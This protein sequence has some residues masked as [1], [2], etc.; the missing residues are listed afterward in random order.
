MGWRGK[1]VGDLKLGVLHI[2]HHARREEQSPPLTRVVFFFFRCLCLQ[3]PCSFPA[4]YSAGYI[5]LNRIKATDFKILN[6][7]RAFIDGDS[8]PYY[9]STSLYPRYPLLSHRDV[10]TDVKERRIVGVFLLLRLPIAAD[11]RATCTSTPSLLYLLCLFHDPPAHRS[12]H[13]LHGCGG[14][15]PSLTVCLW[16]LALLYLYYSNLSQTGG[17]AR[18]SSFAKPQ[19]QLPCGTNWR[20]SLLAATQKLPER[21]HCTGRLFLKRKA[22]AMS[23]MLC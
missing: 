20:L 10:N 19:Q 14:L 23:E 11:L 8:Y 1:A 4:M 9:L 15:F 21:H 7:K 16:R 5:T 6:A 3:Y 18:S 2:P 22:S 12:R 13:L 17:S